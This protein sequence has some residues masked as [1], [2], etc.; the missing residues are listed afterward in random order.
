MRKLRRMLL[1][2]GME[3]LSCRLSRSVDAPPQSVPEKLAC[4]LDLR[5]VMA[6]TRSTSTLKVPSF[7]GLLYVDRLSM[8]R[9]KFDIWVLDRLLITTPRWARKMKVFPGSDSDS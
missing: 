2:V 9:G 5:F 7:V 6:L 1:T 4:L 3:R 8:E